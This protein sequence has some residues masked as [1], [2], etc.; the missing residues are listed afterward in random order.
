MAA[1]IV[2]LAA[3][4]RPPAARHG[5][6]T[7]TGSQL[8]DAPA[9][10]FRFWRGASKA[11]YVHTVYR[12]IDCPDLPAATCIFIKVSPSGRRTVLDVRSVENE[13]ESLNLAEIRFR[14]ANLGATE[15]HVHLLADSAEE[16][17]VTVLDLRAGLLRSLG[18]AKTA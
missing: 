8:P 5:G 10:A 1:Q 15:V 6:Q 16:R 12:L 9:P 11:A 13:A 2:K 17:R 7:G 3:G 14:G 4:H 18:T